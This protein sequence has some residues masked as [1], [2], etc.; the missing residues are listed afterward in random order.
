MRVLTR[1]LV[2]IKVAKALDLT[3]AGSATECL[4]GVLIR[5]GGRE[6][7]THLKV[8][9]S[10]KPP[11]LE[12]PD[13]LQHVRWASTDQRCLVITRGHHQGHIHFLLMGDS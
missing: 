13:Y 2:M 4:C 6:L 1:G 12:S 7:K 8:L 5:K 3:A 11:G 10:V 9:I